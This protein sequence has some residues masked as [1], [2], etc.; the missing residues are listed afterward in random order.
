MP[1]FENEQSLLEQGFIRICGV[2][3]AGRGPLAGPLVV[4]S[5]LFP[6]SFYE[7]PPD[8]ISDL[9]DSK[10]LSTKTR[11]VLY[12]KLL[13]HPE[14]ESSIQVIEPH[15]IDTLNIL[16]ATLHGMVSASEALQPDY[17]LIDGNKLPPTLKIPAKALVKGDQRSYSI[18]AA[19]ILAKVYRDEL[20]E[21]LDLD[22]PG[23][24][25]K[26]HKGYGTKVHLDALA[27]L[28]PCPHHRMSF[29]PVQ[30]AASQAV[31]IK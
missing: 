13:N 30:Q 16:G 12:E 27:T 31:C 4:A 1:S 24:G 19:S 28:G 2:D 22:F 18:A 11:E 17:V 6:S 25:F 15:Q 20:M 29:K 7:C 23:Y 14:I 10:K 9:N 3:E 5:C 26:K 8:F 21:T